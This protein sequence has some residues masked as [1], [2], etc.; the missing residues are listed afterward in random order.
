MDVVAFFRVDDRHDELAKKA[1]CHEPL[2]VIDQ[3]IV[4][5]CTGYAVKYRLRVDE[6]QSMLPEIGAALRLIQVNTVFSVYTYRIF[7]K[8]YPPEVQRSSGWGCLDTPEVLFY[9]RPVTH[10]VRPINR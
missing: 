1:E 7:V 4:F 5:V 3:S 10:A 6:V 8:A 2:L 9:S